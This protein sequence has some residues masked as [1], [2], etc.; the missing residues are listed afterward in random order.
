M[1]R[2]GAA[3]T[4]GRLDDEFVSGLESAFDG[5]PFLVPADLFDVKGLVDAVLAG[6]TGDRAWFGLALAARAGRVPQRE[7][8]PWSALA[9]PAQQR[10]WQQEVC[11]GVR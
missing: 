5:D 10:R 9:D 3:T 11:G 2:W 8:E 7:R 1:T 4:S 6:A